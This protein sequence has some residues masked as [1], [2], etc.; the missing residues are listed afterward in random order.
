MVVA[1]V[2]GSILIAFGIAILHKIFSG[3]STGLQNVYYPFT[4]ILLLIIG[5]WV[6]YGYMAAKADVWHLIPLCIVIPTLSAKWLT[7]VGRT[8]PSF[9]IAAEIERAKR[10]QF[11]S[12]LDKKDRR[13]LIRC[14]TV[15][16]YIIRHVWRPADLSLSILCLC[17]L[18]LNTTSNYINW[19]VK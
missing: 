6:C 9:R 13:C 19:K 11:R 10:K 4:G 1:Y 16:N 12:Y 2:I 18:Y 5:A 15:S 7:R 3:S 8:V 14:T 17:Q